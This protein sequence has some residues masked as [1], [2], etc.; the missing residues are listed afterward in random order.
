M[1]ELSKCRCGRRAYQSLV[2]AVKAADAKVFKTQQPWRAVG[3][4]F[5]DYFHV[6]LKGEVIGQQKRYRPDPFPPLVQK[7]I[8]KRDE[9]RCQRCGRAGLRLERHHRRAKSMGGSTARSHTQCPC[10]ALSLCRS[11]H[12]YVHEHPADS[13]DQGWITRQGVTRPGHSRVMRSIGEDD[14]GNLLD[15]QWATC[16]GRWVH[17]PM[18]AED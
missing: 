14:W 1:S 5:G 2:T 3:C 10:N 7:I 11:C 18:E 9:G 13:R 17:S 8:D 4:S 12:A 16:D 15:P 6:V